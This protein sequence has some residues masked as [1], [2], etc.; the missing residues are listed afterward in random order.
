[1][2]L[3]FLE[4]DP[5]MSHTL[6]L[7]LTHA[8]YIRDDP[9]EA[10]IMRPFPPLGLQYLVAYLK[11]KGM[12]GVEFVDATFH[13]GPEEFRTHLKQ[14]KPKVV[15]LY[16]HT[17]TRS[18]S[19]ELLKMAK[20][21]GCRLIAGGPDPVQYV[22][23]YFSLGVEVIVVGEGEE[24]LHELMG[25]LSQNNWKWDFE[26]LEV[27][28]GIIFLKD[29]EIHRT[30][31]RP[32]IRPIDSLAW[33]SRE[34]SDLDAYFKAWRDRHGET[35][36]SMV[37]S[38]G[39][40]YHCTWCSKQ[41]YGDTFR[42]RS[43]KD[44]ID[45]LL[46]IKKE[47]NPDQIWFADDLFTINKSWIHRFCNEMVA[48]KAVTP[49]YIIGR[50]E[51][52]TEEMCKDLKKAGCFRVYLSAESGAQHILDAMRKEDSVDHIYSAT[53]QLHAVGIEVGFFVMIGYPGE[54][55]RDL[56]ATIN[57][58]HNLQPEV[59]LLS[60]AH[61]M[62]GTQFY[63]SVESRLQPERNS[64]GRMAFDQDYSPRFYELAQRWIWSETRLISQVKKRK[65]RPETFSL[66]LK[67]PIYRLGVASMAR[68]EG[69]LRGY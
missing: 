57:M 23:A 60:V 65:I 58:L 30:A 8:Y 3:P 12:S 50:P 7:L 16:G 52:F 64:G 36:M 22:Q 34:R 35:A 10:E 11:G 56:K 15:G 38:R 4:V 24:T 43:V 32:L 61:P 21:D 63:D 40:P 69:L 51:T 46:Y 17:I 25:H 31:P 66:A 1:M 59:I 2:A 54:R 67:A 29:G 62:K 13:T 19:S 42:R 18:R 48:R 33:P 9:H 53:K 26:G 47:Y 68:F 39:C 37:T 27:I 55:W 45:E 6:D 5:H 49:F 41:V 44:V 20:K 14:K 28:K